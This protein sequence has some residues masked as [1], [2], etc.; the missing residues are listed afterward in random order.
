M[1][2]DVNAL[3]NVFIAEHGYAASRVTNK[4]SGDKPP[5]V[6]R[7]VDAYCAMR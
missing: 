5:T 3:I 4:P 6:K 2:V 7:I 1:A